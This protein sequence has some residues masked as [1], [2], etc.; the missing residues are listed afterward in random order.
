[1]KKKMFGFCVGLFSIFLILFICYKKKNIDEILSSSSYSYLS[2]EAKNYIKSVYEE[3]G[4]LILTE[5]N[6]KE[7]EPY[8]NPAYAEYLS[9]D[10]EEKSSFG[11]IPISLITDYYEVDNNG[12]DT[13]PSSYDLRNVNGKNYVTPNRDQGNLGIC[14]AF[15][16]AG[17]AESYLLKKNDESYDASSLLISERQIDYGTSIDGLKDYDNKYVNFI[18]RNLGSGGNIFVASILMASGVSV[19]NYNDFKS[20][21][22]KDMQVMEASDVINYKKSQYEVN[23]LTVF[24]TLTLRKSTGNLS[25]S[26]LSTYNSYINLVKSYIMNYG[27][28]YTS[29]FV[30]SSCAFY[31][32]TINKNVIDVYN[33]KLSEGHALQIVGWDDNYSYSYCNDYNMHNTDTSNCENIV[34]GTGAWILKNSWGTADAYIYMTYDSQETVIASFTDLNSS[35]Q[36]NW[37]NNYVI[38]NGPYDV[39]YSSKLTYSL[40]NA[41]IKDNEILKKLKFIAYGSNATYE[42]KINGVSESKKYT[43]SLSLPGLT[44]VNIDDI[45]INK[46]STF[47]I[48]STG[49]FLDKV[50]VMTDN[51]N[52]DAYL[53]FSNVDNKSFNYDSYRFYSNV[54]NVDSGETITYKMYNSDNE[55]VT[56]NFDISN[57][58]VIA[59]DI[60][61]L[62]KINDN[63]T[64]GMYKVEALYND[65]VIGSASIYITMMDGSGT[66]EDPYIIT[67]ASELSQIRNNLSAYYV[68]G[69]DID[70]STSTKDGGELSKKSE[71][72]PSYYGWES[73][74]GF[75]GTLDGNGYSIKGLY[76]RG[77]IS[78]TIGSNY[79]SNYTRTGNGLFGSVSGNASIKNLT[80]E[81]FDMECYSGACGMLVS[82]Y[83]ANNYVVGES[84]TDQSTYTANFENIVA[85]NNK[86]K[87]TSIASGT[88]LFGYLLS[89]YGTI[90]IK[91][92]YMNHNILSWE[93]ELSTRAMLAYKIDSPYINIENVRLGGTITDGENKASKSSILVYDLKGNK[94]VNINNV[95]S[96]VKMQNSDSNLINKIYV[97]DLNINNINILS[98]VNDSLFNEKYIYGTNTQTSINILNK[99]SDFVNAINY[100]S[101]NL[102]SPWVQDSF[103]NILRIPTL[104]FANMQYTNIDDIVI[105][106]SLNET[107]N[108]YDYVTPYNETLNMLSYKSNDENIFKISS[109]GEIIPVASGKSTIH[110]ENLYDGYIKDVP[111]TINYLPHYTLKFDSNGGVGNM[112][113]QVVASNV[114]TDL[115]LNSFTKENYEFNGWN[116][117]EDGSGVSYDDGGAFVSN[118]NARDVVLYAQWIG[119]EMTVTFD[120]NGG[121]T[122][123]SSKVVRYGKAYGNLPVPYKDNAAFVSWMCNDEE[124][125][126]YSVYSCDTLKASWKD[127]AYN[128]IYHLSGGDVTWLG[129][130]ENY[131]DKNLLIKV[132]DLS[133]TNIDLEG[134]LFARDNYRLIGWNTSNDGSGTSYDLLEKVNI[135]NIDN[136]QVNL[137][138]MWEEIKNIINTTKDKE[139]IYDDN[140]YSLDINVNVSDYDIKYSLDNENFNLSD[141]PKFKEIGEYT[142]YYKISKDGYNDLTGFNKIKIY[143]IKS[144]DSS[145]TVKE[146]ILVISNQSFNVLKSK[147]NL[148]SNTSTLG[149]FDS[150]Q[151]IVSRDNIKT[152]DNIKINING[153]KDYN[154]YLAYLGDV[155]GDG[156]IGIIDYIRIMKDIMGTQKLSGVSYEAADMNRNGNIDIIDYIRIMKIIME[157][158]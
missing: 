141:S 13:L 37:D 69:N 87:S 73:I 11:N 50:I 8:L 56:S 80:L 125:R 30:H 89:T 83:N 126:N 9:Y 129:K 79:W 103:N 154:Y 98:N 55:D 39:A 81:D 110:I 41:D 86:I 19:F 3:T 68:L 84:L 157:E 4:T 18:R 127:N 134:A 130:F 115:P 21:N 151:N 29:T 45:E 24:P 52:D 51:K 99:T 77:Y 144:I 17:S 61:T 152:G 88:G 26:D 105:N 31:D 101:W 140:E 113:S 7:N 12:S 66:S 131:V 85:K 117:K 145:I 136:S 74:N 63:V 153:I 97:M 54:K 16:S 111:I 64:P 94:T 2:L 139:A 90:N 133:D 48:S 148:L 135:N 92:I 28:A 114:R 108:I 95:I 143:G 100:N 25:D 72:C 43:V 34:N 124:V 75:S 116:T 32:N 155:N 93:D 59:G 70:L 58:V 76:Q 65:N 142:V 47:V 35:Y 128:V 62:I 132:Y 23:G 33:C 78:C 14:W 119:K 149:L 102:S 10:D 106:Q 104:D 118:V 109:D 57:N 91:N 67:N 49:T 40:S 96:T 122:P 44:T 137:Y 123:V 107:Y 6:K 15:A 147:I 121:T 71:Y 5:K 1:V 156:L 138:P 146:N 42:I 36:K 53:D 150:S 112:D 22:D 82:E 46:D 120:A 20:Y 60:N 27:A 158:R 38:S